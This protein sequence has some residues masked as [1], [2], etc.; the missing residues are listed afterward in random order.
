MVGTVEQQLAF[1][2]L[3][4]Y[5]ILDIYLEEMVLQVLMVVVQVRLRQPT[6][7]GPVMA[8]RAARVELQCSYLVL[9]I[10]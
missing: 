9:T 10:P 4:S 2:Q 1:R 5:P 3:Q 6:L 8:V 7:S